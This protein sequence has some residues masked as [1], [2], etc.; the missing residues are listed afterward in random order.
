[1]K[2]LFTFAAMLF[3]AMA[4]NAQETIT[5][6]KATELMPAQEND[7]TEKE[8]TVV[9]YVTQLLS[10]PSEKNGVVQQRFW[11]DDNKGSAETVNCYWC[12][13]PEEAVE[14]G[15]NVGDK[16]SV[17]GKIIN[18]N[19][20][21]ELKNA[22]IVSLESASVVV[23]TYDVDVCEAIEE[24]TSLNANDMSTDI[25]RVHGRLKG[26]DVINSSGKHTFD[27]ACGEET[28]QAYSCAVA[29]GVELGKGD[30]VVVTGKLLYYNG[31]KVEISGGTVEL[32]E[33][34][35]EEVVITDV[36]VAGAIEV[37]MQLEKGASTEDLYAVTGY[38]DSV[39]F[40]HSEKTSV[41]FFMTDDM[42][43]RHF[44]F[45]AY[46]VKCTPEQCALVKA[47]AKVKVT[48]TLKRYYKAAVV[49][50]ENPDN[51]KPEIDLA[52][53]NGGSLEI[54][55]ESAVETVTNQVKT[56]KRIEN[57]QVIFIRNGVRYNALGTE[58]R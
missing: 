47:G 34:S 12:N 19:N 14:N 33:K 41:S 46:S 27:M 13:L 17:T 38:I 57:G 52:E 58:V 53:T 11:M 22:P 54:L 18:Y 44:D 1:M 55:I 31:E 29:E 45:E 26:A 9:G 56:V 8:Y 36:T 25:F 48:A 40:V 6:A 35:Q 30:S 23:E 50:E 10:N 16:I 32:L 49:D 7:E 43:D 4:L 37:A 20:K 3:A 21:P 28:F 42:N 2:K 51:S 39:A 5:C 15:L 24:G